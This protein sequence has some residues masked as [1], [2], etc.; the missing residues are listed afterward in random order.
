M[1]NGRRESATVAVALMEGEYERRLIMMEQ[2]FEV[3]LDSRNLVSKARTGVCVHPS[4]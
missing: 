4:Q 1:K 2:H 3:K